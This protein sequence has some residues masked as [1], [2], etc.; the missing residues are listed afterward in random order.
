MCTLYSEQDPFMDIMYVKEVTL[1]KYFVIFFVNYQLIKKHFQHLPNMS[2]SMPQVLDHPSPLCHEFP[3]LRD[4][5]L[6]EWSLMYY[7][8]ETVLYIGNWR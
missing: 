7:G 8:N 4:V 5:E 1:T 3:S 6:V 2:K